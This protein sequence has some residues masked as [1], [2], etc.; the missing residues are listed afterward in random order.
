MQSYWDALWRDLWGETKQE[1][2]IDQ[3]QG[4]KPQSLGYN[5]KASQDRNSNLSVEQK[6]KA[7]GKILSLDKDKP[8]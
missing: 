4:H 3:G 8:L 1:S 7:P 6:K 2:D 5:R